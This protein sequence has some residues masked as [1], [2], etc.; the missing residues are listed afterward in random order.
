MRN[1]LQYG[2]KTRKGVCLLKSYQKQERFEPS[3]KISLLQTDYHDDES[4][5]RLNGAEPKM[6]DGNSN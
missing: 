5:Y 4:I 2:Y 1:N 3:Q 6:F